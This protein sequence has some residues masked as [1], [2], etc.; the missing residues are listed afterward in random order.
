MES[1]NVYKKNEYK[2]YLKLIIQNIKYKKNNILL[3]KNKKN[4]TNSNNSDY[5]NLLKEILKKNKIN[6]FFL[7][8]IYTH[9][10]VE[11]ILKFF[12]VKEI[13]TPQSS[14]VYT[15]SYFLSNKIKI[16]LIHSKNIKKKFK[17]YAE[18]QTNAI[19]FIKQNYIYENLSIINID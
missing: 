11:I 16:N 1:D 8:P 6:Y 9:I 7:N 5:D 10:P 17:N 4:P 19:N 14:V 13:F 2:N 15:T 3:I 18:L 12:K